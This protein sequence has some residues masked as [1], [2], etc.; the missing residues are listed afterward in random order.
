MNATFSPAQPDLFAAGGD[1]RTGPAP[2]TPEERVRPKLNAVLDS[3]RR[4]DTMP[5]D[6]RDLKFWRVVFPQMSNWLPEAERE[7]MRA[8]F[9]RELARLGA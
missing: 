2:T 9:R 5:L 8:E 1:G 3:L 4:A 6:A 7:A